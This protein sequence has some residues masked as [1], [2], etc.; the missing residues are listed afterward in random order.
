M[1][2]AKIKRYLHYKKYNN[3]CQ[4]IKKKNPTMEMIF[5]LDATVKK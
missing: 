5:F 4:K 2:K 3:R 1:S